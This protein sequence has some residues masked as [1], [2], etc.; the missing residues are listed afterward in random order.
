MHAQHPQRQRMRLRQHPQ[1]HQGHGGRQVGFFRQVPNRLRRVNHPAAQIE[2][3]PFRRVNHCR[4]LTHAFRREGRCRGALARLWQRFQLNGRRL[5]VLRNVYP[6]RPGTPGLGNTEG[7]ADHL[8]QLGDVAH[9]VVM[10][11]D[12]DRDAVG[13][14]FL[15]SVGADHGGRHLAGDADQRD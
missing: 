14:H 8:R 1:R 4:R 13:V 12:G 5:Y 6:H 9:Q 2:H 11:G 10:L 3:R 15:E 7:V